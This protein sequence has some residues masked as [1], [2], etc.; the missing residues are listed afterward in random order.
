MLFSSGDGLLSLGSD[1][2]VGSSTGVS[3][4]DTVNSS[5]L[6]NPNQLKAGS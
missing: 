6:E 4:T 5:V 2:G 1:T 3:G